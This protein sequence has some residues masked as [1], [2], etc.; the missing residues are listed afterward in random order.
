MVPEVSRDRVR[1]RFPFI[2]AATSECGQEGGVVAV[3]LVWFNSR[4]LDCGSRDGG[5]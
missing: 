4:T 5:A 2:L 3:N 1:V